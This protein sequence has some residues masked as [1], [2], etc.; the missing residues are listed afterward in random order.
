ME[1]TNHVPADL[2]A[3]FSVWLCKPH[4][5]FLKGRTMFANWD[6][7]EMKEMA[8]KIHK[9]NLLVA[10]LQGWPWTEGNQALLAEQ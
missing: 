6:P 1:H 4:A 7:E 2:P 10:S 3:H 8:N 9:D 5:D